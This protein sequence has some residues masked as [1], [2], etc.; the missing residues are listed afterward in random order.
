MLAFLPLCDLLLLQMSMSTVWLT[1]RT[2]A[3]IVI[4][5]SLA[6]G[7]KQEGGKSEYS[8]QQLQPNPTLLINKFA[9]GLYGKENK[10]SVAVQ[11]LGSHA[12]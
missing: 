10:E 9:S 7:L 3:K 1:L 6:A 8:I 11:G 5:T 12:N 4:I 2:I